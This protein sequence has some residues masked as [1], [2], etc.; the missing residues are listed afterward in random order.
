[1]LKVPYQRRFNTA[2]RSIITVVLTVFA[3][4]SIVPPQRAFAQGL[5]LPMPG[6]MLKVSSQFA[7]PVIQGMKIDP[8]NPLAFNFL[9]DPG[10]NAMTE[11]QK[12]TEYTKLIKYFLASLTTPESDMWVNLSPY[13]HSRIISKNFG[14]TE[15]GRD[16]LAQDYLLKQLTASL[17]YPE[18][19]LGK[20]FW[21][22]IYERV[23]TEFGN[24]QVP[25]NT[26]NK[27][28]ILP[29]SATVYEKGNVA[30]VVESHLQ[31]MMEADYLALDRGANAAKM[32][33]ADGKLKAVNNVSGK[34]VKEIIIP[35]IEQQINTG[36]NFAQLR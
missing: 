35:E 5:S 2:F 14:G 18:D 23:R 17:M 1:M 25:V 33:L 10:Q 3:T 21:D 13:E 32:G 9:V 15:M 6:T 19:A 20:K 11:A 28:W 30:M 29:Q 24:T 12:K 7:P 36:C 16:M 4:T 26:F 31:V 22:R 8:N 27:V 34:V